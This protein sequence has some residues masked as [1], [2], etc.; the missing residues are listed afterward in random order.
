MS[1][2]PI[3][4]LNINLL[5]MLNV[6]YACINWKQGLYDLFDVHDNKRENYCLQGKEI[7]G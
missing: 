6:V 2:N 1:D 7:D 3:F 5:N 4:T